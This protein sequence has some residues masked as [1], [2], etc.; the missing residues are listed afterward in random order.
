MYQLVTSSLSRWLVSPKRYTTVG[1]SNNKDRGHQQCLAFSPRLVEQN[2]VK[3]LC[4]TMG[5]CFL[6]IAGTG[7]AEARVPF[8]ANWANGTPGKT[9]IVGNNTL[10]YTKQNLLQTGTSTVYTSTV[11]TATTTIVN[12]YCFSSVVDILVPPAPW[13]SFRRKRSAIE[14]EEQSAILSVDGET[15][16]PSQVQK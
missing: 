11:F 5:H 7:Q 6:Q 10:V 3:R 9:H 2:K 15:I 13:C 14:E 16:K 8:L 1:Q 12:A 4:S